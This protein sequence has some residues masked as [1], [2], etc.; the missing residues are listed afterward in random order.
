MKIGIVGSG[1]VGAT[2]AYAFIMQGVGREI[3]LVDK[4]EARARA[5]A[6]DLLHAVPFANPMR[7][8]AGDYSDL[9]G[10]RLVILAAGTNQRPGESRLDLLQRNA[11]I[12]RQIVPQVLKH[13]PEAVLV[14]ATNPVD[15]LTHFAAKFATEEGVSSSR[16]L[17]SG[18]TLDTARFRSLLG[19]HLGVDSQHVHAYVIGE[20]GDSEVLAW[21]L[22]TIG[23]MS[24]E[25][26]C[27]KRG[28]GCQE[29]WDR[30]EREVREA[31]YE[32]IEGKGATYY[33]IGSA[34]ARIGKAVLNDQRAILTVC[35]PTPEVAGVE[36]VTV[37]LPRLIGGQG[38]LDTFPKPLN[39]EEWDKLR[40]SAQV[41]RNAIDELESR[42]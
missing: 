38:I 16:V 18:T 8:Q 12:F 22:V 32:I 34:L 35:T 3:V 31:A 17:G 42:S 1:F 7:V 36:D 29:D 27:K 14:V 15:I 2:A 20:H 6:S 41:V 11:G 25:E 33:G 21:S 13:A 24:L 19:G 4:D 30:I 23:G 5:E 26:F 40:Q 10:S 9:D 28:V 39:Q 37:S